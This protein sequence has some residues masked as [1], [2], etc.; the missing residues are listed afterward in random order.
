MDCVCVPFRGWMGTTTDWSAF[1]QGMV[2]GARR[3]GLC[4]KLQRCW[5]FHSQQFP[6]C[7]KNGLPPKRTSSQLDNWGKHW[8][9]HGPASLRNAWHFVPCPD[10][11]RLLRA[12]GV[13]LNIRKV[14]LMFCPLSVNRLPLLR[15]GILWNRFPENM[16]CQI[17][18]THRPVGEPCGKV[19]EKM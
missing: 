7:I 17:K 12:K 6:L 15:V 3:T 14:F 4:Q 1:E 10:K 13:Q 11:L 16:G 2:V 19:N 9:Q 5:G 8:S 18:I